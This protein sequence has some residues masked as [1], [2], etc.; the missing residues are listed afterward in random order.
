MHGDNPDIFSINEAAFSESNQITSGDD[1]LD[2]LSRF[3]AAQRHEERSKLLIAARL[4]APSVC[5]NELQG[6]EKL[7]ELLKEKG[8]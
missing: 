1:E 4:I 7:S 8:H 6:F 5:F 3:M 2:G